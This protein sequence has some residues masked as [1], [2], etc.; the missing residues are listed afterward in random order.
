[1]NEG[2]SEAQS[3]SD[4]DSGDADLPW[5]DEGAYAVVRMPMTWGW[6]SILGFVTAF[7]YAQYAD[8]S[9]G[10]VRVWLELSVFLVSGLIFGFVGRRRDRKRFPAL[11]GRLLNGGVLFSCLVSV[12]AFY[13][14]RYDL[15]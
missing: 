10:L 2:I 4:V 1:M 14:E 3:P 9:R 8:W 5:I 15:W 6:A 13:F 12:V 7:T 11:A